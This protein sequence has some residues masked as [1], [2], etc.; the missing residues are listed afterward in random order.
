M[1]KPTH[2]NTTTTH[3]RLIAAISLAV[4]STAF[5]A[6]LDTAQIDKSTGLKGSMDKDESVYKVT[7]P[8]DDVKVTVAGWQMPPFMGLG[9]WAAFRGQMSMR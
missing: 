1:K 9:T 2:M 8:R 4:A 6:E 5:A 3:W 7:F